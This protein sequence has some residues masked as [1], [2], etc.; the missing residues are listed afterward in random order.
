M[1]VCGS[2]YGGRG[3][4]SRPPSIM[5]GDQFYP[6]T[7]IRE[8]V[9]VQNKLRE[10]YIVVIFLVQRVLFYLLFAARLF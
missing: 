2:A 6:L 10:F 7:T 3:P 4:S 1:S 8:S 9:K 5:S